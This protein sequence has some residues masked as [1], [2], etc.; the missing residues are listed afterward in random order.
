MPRLKPVIFIS[1]IHEDAGLANAL[2][3]FIAE[4]FLGFFEIFVSSDGASI[5]SG[6]N[7]SDAIEAALEKSELVLV[8]LSH[9]AAERRWIYFESGGAY[10]SRK[11]VIPICC[12]G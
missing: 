1:H 2:Q 12:R 9:E 4:A 11:R 6:D 7:W 8:L 3:A 5:R 10:F